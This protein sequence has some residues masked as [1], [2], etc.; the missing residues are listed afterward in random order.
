M[1]QVHRPFLC[2]QMELRSVCMGVHVS[3]Q[4]PRL[5][6]LVAEPR[7]N[8]TVVESSGYRAISKSVVGTSV[9]ELA[10]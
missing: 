3:S 1:E 4:V 5:I 7:P 8:R 9:G 10:A 6:V 2:P